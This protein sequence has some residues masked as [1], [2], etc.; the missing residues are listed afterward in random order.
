MTTAVVAGRQWIAANAIQVR[1]FTQWAVLFLAVIAAAAASAEGALLLWGQL[2][3]SPVVSAALI[4]TAG[5]AAATA[6]GALPVLAARNVSQKVTT[7]MLGFG[8]GV[9]LA[10]TAFSLIVPGIES[11]V[12]MTGNRLLAVGVVS[13]ALLAGGFLMLAM[14]RAVP[15]EHFVKGVNGAS[16]AEV[17]RIWLFVAAIALHNFPEGLAVGVGFGSGDIASGTPL[18]IGIGVQNIPEGLVVALALVATGYS[19]GF[20]AAIAA[21][22][23]LL[24]PIGGILG[25]SLVSTSTTLLPWG[26]GLAAG[27][28]LFVVSHE[29]IP[30]SHRKGH[31]QLATVGL[32]AGFVVMMTLDTALG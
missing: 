30:E 22:T 31:E 11:A 3:S 14:D 2:T 13:L 15:H 21:A 10:A 20:A 32:M 26:L 5:T 27:A 17:K 1:R 6:F 28:M 19:A 12:V 16:A 8:A 7:I 23:G 4:A 9:M 25:A 18:A 24:E 29:I